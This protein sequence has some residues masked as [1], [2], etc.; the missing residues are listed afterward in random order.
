MIE[1]EQFHLFP[2][3]SDPERLPLTP[4]EEGNL[5]SS[6]FATPQPIRQITGELTNLYLYIDAQG[7]AYVSATP[8]DLSYHITVSQ[9]VV[10]TPLD[11]PPTIAATASRPRT[12]DAFRILKSPL[13]P[14]LSA[15]Q[16]LKK[17]PDRLHCNNI[18][19]VA[20]H[21]N[22]SSIAN[23]LLGGAYAPAAVS[24]RIKAA[25]K[26]LASEFNIDD[27]ALHTAFYRERILHGAYSPQRNDMFDDTLLAI[28]AAKVKKAMAW[29]KKGGSRSTALAPSSNTSMFID[30][31]ILKQTTPVLSELSIPSAP[32]VFSGAH[33]D[34]DARYKNVFCLNKHIL[35]QHPEDAREFLQSVKTQTPFACPGLTD[36]APC[37]GKFHARQ[38][39]WQHICLK[40]GADEAERERLL[41][42]HFTFVSRDWI[43]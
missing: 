24:R 42:Q 40:H 38:D 26:W 13:S 18:L 35:S 11:S 4:N 22:N 14:H 19:K 6:R 9:S 25:I 16:I 5:A 20:L 12:A 23:H 10:P 1:Y 32:L 2:V 33:P 37:L 34:C 43:P 8:C 36:G 15:Q 41:E 39:R 27:R 28:N 29:V 3:E 31:S 17:Y 7:T 30:D 21:Y